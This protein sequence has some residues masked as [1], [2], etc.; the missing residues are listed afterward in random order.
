MNTSQSDSLYA[1]LVAHIRTTEE[2]SFVLQ[3]CTSLEDSIYHTH[4]ERAQELLDELLPHQLAAPVKTALREARNISPRIELSVFV[5]KLR[6][7]LNS[8]PVLSLEMTFEPSEETIALLSRWARHYVQEVVILEL[9][10]DVLLLGG[11]RIAWNGRYLEVNL[12]NMV[13]DALAHEQSRIQKLL[14]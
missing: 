14:T 1:S 8:L 2:R 7:I 4:P 5:A 12:A 9:R 10:K 13:E 3:A 11:V 6:E